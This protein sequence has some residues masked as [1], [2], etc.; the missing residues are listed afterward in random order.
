MANARKWP[1][2]ARTRSAVAD[3]K[4]KFDGECP[5]TVPQRVAVSR[6]QRLNS[7]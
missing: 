4:R 3:P 2:A 7:R 6:S 1:T 5:M